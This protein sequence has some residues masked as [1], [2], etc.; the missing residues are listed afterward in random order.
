MK[1]VAIVLL[2]C[3]LCIDY[4]AVEDFVI[5]KKSSIQSISSLKEECITQ[6]SYALQKLAHLNKEIIDAAIDIFEG[7]KMSKTDLEHTV[8]NLTIINGQLNAIDQILLSTKQIK[9]S[10]K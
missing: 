1:K 5:P 7:K 9:V 2:F 8:N 4:G 3:A 10:Q 6:S